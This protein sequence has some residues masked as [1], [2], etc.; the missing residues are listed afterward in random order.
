MWDSECVLHAAKYKGS[1]LKPPAF[2]LNAQILPPVARY[3]GDPARGKQRKV[4]QSPSGWARANGGGFVLP[5]G[6][7]LPLSILYG[8]Q[9]MGHQLVLSFAKCLQAGWSGLHISCT[10]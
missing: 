7:T 2:P 10:V 8:G 6:L 1:G 5:R 9:T 3:P 4:I